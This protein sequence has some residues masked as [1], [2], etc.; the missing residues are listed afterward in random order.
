VIARLESEVSDHR[1]THLRLRRANRK[2]RERT[3]RLHA[4]ALQLARAEE[5]ER[6]RLSHLLHDEM[7]QLL[8]GARLH[9]AVLQRGGEP[10][11]MADSLQYVTSLL[12]RAIAASRQLAIELSPPVLYE[13]GLTEALVSLARWSEQ[14]HGVA[15]AF[16]SSEP[17]GVDDQGVAAF[18]FQAVRELVFNVAKHS[19]VMKTAVTL[20]RADASSIRIVVADEGKGFVASEGLP[21]NR[22]EG[23]GLFSIRERAEAL[24]GS[25]S[26]ES[27]PGEGTR[28]FLELPFPSPA[29]EDA[30][31]SA[32]ERERVAKG[33]APIRVLIADDHQ[34]FRNGLVAILKGEPDI[35]IVGEAADGVEAIEKVRELHPDV[36][37]M[38]ISMPRMSG[39]DATRAIAAEDPRPA[40][41]I[42]SMYEAR[43]WT[44]PTLEA[45]A[46]AFLTKGVSAGQ[47]LTAVRHAAGA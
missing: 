46:S 43:D 45:G 24:G 10:D 12:D 41:V 6:R 26:I 1:A 19:G 23:F 3:K 18:A 37:V 32:S 42:L 30:A 29:S 22:H 8:A 17:I 33:R 44:Q 47:L 20:D 15:V 27:V 7:Q 39:L 21:A 4:L 35:I 9:A 11:V 16:E 13:A 36:V 31:S 14:H 34:V 5:I 38:D 28:V 40:V 2:L 25:F